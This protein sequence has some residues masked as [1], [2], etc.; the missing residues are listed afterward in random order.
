MENQSFT[1]TISVDQTPQEAFKAITNLRGWWS[2]NI[3]GGTEK[4]NDVFFY[5]M[6]LQCAK[7]RYCVL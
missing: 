6:K 4:L 1:A 5:S 2:E 3:E 7:G